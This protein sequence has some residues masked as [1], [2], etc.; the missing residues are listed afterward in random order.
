MLKWIKI[1]MDSN[2][3]KGKKKRKIVKIEGMI[4]D[5]KVY[6]RM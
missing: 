3:G 6:D 1:K 2:I 4:L 5:K